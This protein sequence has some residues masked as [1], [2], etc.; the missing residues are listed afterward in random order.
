MIIYQIFVKT[1]TGK[2]I[3]IDV[4][5][6]D[7]IEQLKAKIAEKEGMPEDQQRIIY[8]GQELN[9]VKTLIDYNIQKEAT[10]HMSLR[11]R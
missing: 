11:L 10:L 5:E 7:T 3:S 2:T 9:N 6:K 8:A 4:T 1:L